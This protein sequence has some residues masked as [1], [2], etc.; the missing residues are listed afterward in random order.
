MGKLV[1]TSFVE[2]VEG[3]TVRLS[4]TTERLNRFDDAEEVRFLPGDMSPVGYEKG[5]S[6]WPY[7]GVGPKGAGVGALGGMTGDRVPLGEVNVRRGDQVHATDGWIGSVHGL[8]IDPADHHVTHVLLQE[9]HIFAHKEVAIPIGSTT[10]VDEEI[11]VDLTMAQIEELPP[12]EL[13]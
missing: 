6:S 2:G 11:R 5:V 3:D 9:G 4:C 1:P 8:V 12:V 13:G 10:R 7:F